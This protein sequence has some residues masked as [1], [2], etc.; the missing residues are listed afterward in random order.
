MKVSVVIPAYDAAETLAETLE[1][2]LAQT[3]PE[4]E[5]IVVDD[6]SRDGT[7]AVVEAFTARDARIRMIRQANAGEAAARNTGIADARHDWL[8]FLDSD[9]WIAAE[10]L[11]RMTG[12]LTAEPGLDAVHCGYARVAADGSLVVEKYLPPA[13]DMFAIWARRSAFPVHACVVRKALVEAAGGFDVSFR[14]SADWDL[15]QRIARTGARFGAI[16]DVLAYYRMRPGAASLGAQYMLEDGLRV[17]RKGHA[18][19]PRV[20]HPH[21]DH[22]QGAPQEQIPSQAFYLLSWCAGLLLGSGQDARPLLKQLEGVRF[23]DLYPP[24]VA[25]ILFEAATLPGCSPPSAWE[26]LWPELLRSIE[27]FLVALEEHTQASALAERTRSALA[28]MVLTHAPSW[29][30]VMREIDAVGAA[31]EARKDYWEGI[32]SQR[33]AAIVELTAGKVALQRVLEERVSGLEREQNALRESLRRSAEERN[34]LFHSRERRL[35]DL[36][37][38]RLR[39]ARPLAAVHSLATALGQRVVVARL[40]AERWFSSRRQRRMVA[41]ICWNFPIY[42]QTFVYQELTQLEREGM[43]L[44]LVYSRLDPHD[45]LPGSF[46]HLWHAR[47]R[48]FL[49]RKVHERD[50]AHYRRRMPDRVAVVTAKLCQASGLSEQDLLGHGNFLE[51]FSFARM[52]EAYRPDYLHSYFFYDRSLMALVAGYLLQIP[53][54]ISCYADHVLKDYELKVVPLHLE[55]C[56]IVVATS[57]RIK[58]ELVELAPRADASR[59]LV[60][61]N[62]IDTERFSLRERSEPG[63]G[64]P[65][66]LVTVCRIE[67]KKGLVELVEAVGLLRDRGQRVEAHVVGAPDEWSAESRDY[68]RRVDQRISELNLWG[69]VHLEGRQTL[70]GVQRMLGLAHLFVAPFVETE[71]GDKD[72]IPTALLEG[73][74]TGLPAVATDAG[75]IPEVIENGRDGVLV[76]QRNPAALADA[77][78][79]LIRDRE[80]RVRLGQAA[81]ETIR[82]RFDARTCETVFHSQVR[83]LVERPRQR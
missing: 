34:A 50:F 40:A 47:R 66:R 6:G 1:S 51:A 56:D 13:G 77:I 39:L 3:H 15:W 82:R 73:M 59:I 16:R 36:L 52:L 28:R 19:D 10:F 37:L 23:P 41:T 35:G 54:G 65:F 53:R 69:S 48:L 42:S 45:Q 21:P 11:E 12:A 8:L 27:E 60:K 70:E 81:A 4:W 72:G 24:A 46:E 58:R 74:A 18:P 9:D 20:P 29:G 76:P 75:S 57:E 83:T 80:R 38:H 33:Q 32:A 61:P 26:R 71:S 25:Q 17:L 31:L 7:A 62:G 55:L 44:R 14:K 68:K 49:N 64:M 78:E 2:L 5:A 30:P 67:P 63:D 22:A 43:T 79:L